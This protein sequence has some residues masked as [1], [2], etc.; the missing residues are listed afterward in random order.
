MSRR[1]V[2]AAAV[3]VASLSSW[4]VRV[5][6]AQDFTSPDTINAI[7]AT[8]ATPIA[9]A[10]ADDAQLQRPRVQTPSRIGGSALMPSLYASTA[11]M[12]AL[13]L[14]STMKGLNAGAVEGNPMMSGIV[15]HKA[16]FVAVKAG[17]AVS[18]MLAVRQISKHNR[19][20]AVLTAVGINSLYAAVASHNYRVARAAGRR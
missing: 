4:T 12:Q 16:A 7:V 5:A 8:S 2:I 13:D 6:S 19:V 1:L 14:H 17:V 15:E 20:A 10:I 11:V 3:I 9:K 18:T